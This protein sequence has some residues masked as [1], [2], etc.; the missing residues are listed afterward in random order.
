MATTEQEIAAGPSLET[1]E[2]GYLMAAIGCASMPAQ[3]SVSYDDVT[4]IAEWRADGF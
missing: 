1:I 4:T 3:L 2:F